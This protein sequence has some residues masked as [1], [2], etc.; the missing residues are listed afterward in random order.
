[1]SEA[2]SGLEEGP[3]HRLVVADPHAALIE[4]LP[5]LYPE[6]LR[7]SGIHPTSVIHT[8]AVLPKGV[9]VGP[10]TVIGAGARLGEGV[11]IGANCVVGAG[12]AI[13]AGT[14]LYPNVTLYP[15]SILGDRVIVHAGARIG[16]DG[17]GYVSS[18]GKHR[19]IPQVGACVV[20]DDV[21]IGGNCTIDRGSIGRTVIGAGSKLDNLVHVGHNVTIGPG[22]M[23]V[24][25]V[26]VAGSTR[27]GEGVALG[28]QAGISGHLTV[29]ARAR[30]AAQA[31]VIGDV[32]EDQAV[33]GYPARDH[34][35]Y[36]KAMAHLMK[37]PT[38]VKRI[39]QIE[40]REAAGDVR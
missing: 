23:L 34:R 11:R 10:H 30:V 5:L 36:L 14:V 38:I 19:K 31:G 32:A 16:V 17:F 1:M 22:S 35:K 18:G 33:S 20:E 3:P 25:Q 39:D 26:G 28:G 13:G 21:E 8:T 24:A 9:D 15:G 7:E 37:L 2:L 29:G 12:V 4:L 6:R 27:I 40:R